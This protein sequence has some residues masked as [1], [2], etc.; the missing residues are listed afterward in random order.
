MRVDYVEDAYYTVATSHS[1]HVSLVA[2]IHCKACATK[3]SDL[4]ARPEVVVS[5]EDFDL[6]EARATSDNKIAFCL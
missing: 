4:S 5:I 2:E 1:E 3:V 6:V